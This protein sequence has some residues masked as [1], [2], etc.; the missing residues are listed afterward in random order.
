[1]E[2]RCYNGDFAR[3][4]DGVEPTGSAIGIA[5]MAPHA[6]GSLAI[7]AAG[8]QEVDLGVV[9]PQEV[10]RLRSWGERVVE[11]LT[12]RRFA[13]LVAAD[14]VTVDDVVLTSQHAWGSMPM[15]ELTD[16]NGG[17]TGLDGLRV[18]DGSILP[19]PGSSGPH[20]TL[21]MTASVIA[22]RLSSG[23]L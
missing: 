20:A 8:V 7:D 22:A 3:Y 9:D 16:V 13:R 5:L 11:M 10:T 14:T 2:I 17:V 1:M 18:I 15:G 12:D 4:I 19:G 21:M 23:R 6:A